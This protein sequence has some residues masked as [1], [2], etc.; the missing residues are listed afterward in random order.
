MLRTRDLDESELPFGGNNST[1]TE[2]QH[3]E[4]PYVYF[5]IFDGHAGSATAVTA[6]NELHQVFVTIFLWYIIVYA[7][8][9]LFADR[10]QTTNG[11][12]ET[13]DQPNAWGWEWRRGRGHVVSDKRHFV[14]ITSDRYEN[15]TLE[16]L[17][18]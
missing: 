1:A 10:S 2:L 4:I 17:A 12:F 8:S 14:G 9:I 15:S 18:W 11:C 16:D 3:F 13:P 6:A 5:G 7:Y